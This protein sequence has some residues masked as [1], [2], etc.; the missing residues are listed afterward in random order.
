MAQSH[1]V[2][3]HRARSRRRHVTRRERL[4]LRAT[5]LDGFWFVVFAS[6]VAFGMLLWFVLPIPTGDALFHLAR[7]RK[8]LALDELSLDAVGEFVDGGLHPGYAFPLWH[9]F[10]ALVAR[11]ADVD[12]RRRSGTRAPCSRRSRSS[13]STRRGAKRSARPGSARRRSSRPSASPPCPSA[14][15]ERSARSR[16]RRPPGRLLLVPAVLALL[17]AYL[18]HPRRAGL[19]LLGLGSFV[20]AVVH[21]TYA[22]FVVLLAAGFLCAQAL[23]DRGELR[24]VATA[25]AALAV[26]AGVFLVWLFP[27]VETAASY[28]PTNEQLTGRGTGSSVIR[29]E[30]DFTS[31]NRYRLAP[32]V[33]SRSGPVPIAG[34]VLVPLA[35]LAARRR[36]AG[37]V[38]GA[39]L[40]ALLVLLVPF[41]FPRFVDA[42]S[43]S[44]ARRLAGFIP[45]AFA[46]AGGAAILARFLSY[47]LLPV[48]LVAGFA[49]ERAYPGDFGY[50]LD[51]GGPSMIVWLALVLG[52]LALAVGALLRPPLPALERADWV[53]FAAVALFVLPILADTTWQR[54]EPATELTHGLVEAVRNDVPEGDVVLSDPETSYWLAA[55][56]PVYVAVAPP[57]HVGDTEKNRPQERVEAW[58]RFLAT[59]RFDGRADW[60]VI[61]RLRARGALPAAT[62][63]RRA[64]SPLSALAGF[65][66][67]LGLGDER[68]ERVEAAVPEPRFVEVEA[69]TLHQLRRRLRPTCAEQPEDRLDE[70]LALLDVAL[71]DREREQR[72]ERVRVHVARHEREVRVVAPERPEAVGQLDRVAVHALVHADPELPSR[73]ADSSPSSRRS[74]C[75]ASSNRFAAMAPNTVPAI[76]SMNATSR[77]IR[78]FVSLWSRSWRNVIASPSTDPV[79]ASVSGTSLLK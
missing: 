50:T 16:S 56:A 38:L 26:G 31:P 4:W 70:R 27:V 19:V 57:A 73:V 1:K 23:L 71:V 65:R 34:L 17:F 53:P 48:A 14:P 7:I 3:G 28:T 54:A 46:L 61:D 49:V 11:V 39:T 12:P 47:A 60:L 63:R 32:E 24:R 52:G 51:Q 59:N 5:K 69:D 37:Y 25:F 8:L 35:L 45:F 21:P 41:V 43:L 44:Q 67:G 76:S 29:A 42:V 66:E 18:N 78:S 9:G 6:G 20:L 68:I 72:A 2:P 55:Y 79:S 33:V 15:A 40:T 13:S 62:L 22:L 77:S 75:A 10:V 64:L 74:L 30:I 58:R 36:W